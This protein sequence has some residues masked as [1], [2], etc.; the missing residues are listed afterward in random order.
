MLSCATHVNYFAGSV[1]C[2][3]ERAAG[4]LVRLLQCAN[5]A[6]MVAT[7]GVVVGSVGATYAGLTVDPTAAILCASLIVFYSLLLGALIDKVRAAYIAA[8][9][10]DNRALGIVQDECVATAERLSALVAPVIVIR[11]ALTC[12]RFDREEMPPAS[13]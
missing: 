13:V 6:A 5:A 2:G 9:P 11:T 12:R 10:P 8:L 1:S 3:G 4:D 7:L